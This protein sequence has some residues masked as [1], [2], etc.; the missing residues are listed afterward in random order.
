[1]KVKIVGFSVSMVSPC[2]DLKYACATKMAKY[3][4]DLMHQKLPRYAIGSIPDYLILVLLLEVSLECGLVPNLG[5]MYCNEFLQYMMPRLLVKLKVS[6][7]T[8]LN[9]AIDNQCT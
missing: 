1:M 9:P 8:H 3:R 2:L 7:N 5:I 6:L 4:T